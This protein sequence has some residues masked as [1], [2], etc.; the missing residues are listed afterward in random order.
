MFFKNK[1]TGSI[2]QFAIA[3][4]D[5]WQELTQSEINA[6]EL[7]QTKAE[8]IAQIKGAAASLILATYPTHRQ[9]NTLMSQ[10]IP[11]IDEMNTFIL[12]IR[13]RSSELEAGL[14][15]LSTEEIKNYPI[16]FTS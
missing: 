14:E 9:L 15:G 5:D 10:D 7:E 11:L 16:Q 3:Q 1:I 8:K 6:Y 13:T 12:G 4:G 2:G